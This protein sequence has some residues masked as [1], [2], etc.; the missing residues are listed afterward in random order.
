MPN[1]EV[2]RVRREKN[3]FFLRLKSGLPSRFGRAKLISE[4]NPEQSLQASRSPFFRCSQSDGPNPSGQVQT[5]A[6]RSRLKHFEL[7]DVN[8]DFDH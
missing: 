8:P 2:G 3:G 1:E 4:H 7:C 5:C 6:I